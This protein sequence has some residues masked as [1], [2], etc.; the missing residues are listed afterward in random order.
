MEESE[1]ISYQINF[2]YGVH[3]P[4]SE[5]DYVVAALA[6]SKFADLAGDDEEVEIG[7][8]TF[9]R[10]VTSEA[11]STRGVI[12]ADEMTHSGEEVSEPTAFCRFDPATLAELEDKLS[13]SVEIIT[14]IYDIIV[15]HYKKNQAKF[16]AIVFWLASI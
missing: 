16:N 14:D 6:G 11:S 7:G 8:H 13:E 5:I 1:E 12:F 10:N 3:Y 2:Y 9:M 4:V 15:A